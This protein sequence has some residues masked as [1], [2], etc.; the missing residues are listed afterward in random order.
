MLDESEPLAGLLRKCLL[1]GAETGSD[2]LRDWARKELNG[3][4]DDDEV[5]EYRKVRTAISVDSLSGNTWMSGQIIDRHQL[6]KNCW[7][8]VHD[9]APMK[10]PIEELEQMATRE[11]LSFTNPALGY[12]QTLWNQSLGPFQ[13]VYNI[14]YVT[15]GSAMRGTLGQIR[16]HLVD[17]IA[18][19]TADTPLTELPRK[20]QVDAALSHRVGDVYNTTINQADGPVAIGAK[21]SATADGLTLDD[22]LRL[23]DKVREVAGGVN[24]GRHDE[25]MEAVAEL[26]EAVAKESPDTGEVVKKAGALRTIGER[27]GVA[28]VSSAVNSAI[29]AITNL[30]MS[31]AFG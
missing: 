22:A 12:A 4:G 13:A 8:Y 25:L 1:L 17:L 31:G 27:V 29:G 14:T 2:A 21:A 19:L 6:P 18:D 24:G 11:R 15:T 16:T 28:A 20:E 9:A 30:A 10:Q 26:R 3:Y 7:E 5:P 23:L